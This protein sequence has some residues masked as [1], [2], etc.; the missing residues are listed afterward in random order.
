MRNLIL[1]L[2]F[3]VFLVGASG[4]QTLKY[5]TQG[6]ETGVSKGLAGGICGLGRSLA[7]DAKSVWSAIERADAWVEENYW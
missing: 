7:A 1:G 2:L 5:T 3:L 4:C 6:V